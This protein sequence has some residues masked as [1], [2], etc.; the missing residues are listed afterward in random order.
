[1]LVTVLFLANAA[2]W[3]TSATA[4]SSPVTTKKERKI[5][6]RDKTT[7]TRISNY[8]CMTKQEWDQQAELAKSDLEGLR[9][10]PTM[11]IGNNKNPNPC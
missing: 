2:I 9:E 3:D 10:R 6:R 7:N 4:G 8:V 1:M 5:C 11:C